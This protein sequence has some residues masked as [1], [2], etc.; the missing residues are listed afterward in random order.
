MGTI[1]VCTMWAKNLAHIVQTDLGA[2]PLH[3]NSHTHT[4]FVCEGSVGVGREGWD[5]KKRHSK[6]LEWRF[7]STIAF[8]AVWAKYLAHTA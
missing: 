3:P 4:I 6:I 5:L 1:T 2:L 7:L 8:Y